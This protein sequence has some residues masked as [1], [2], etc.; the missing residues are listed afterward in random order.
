MNKKKII[1]LSIHTS[2]LVLYLFYEGT[3]WLNLTCSSSSVNVIE[4]FEI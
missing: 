2:G 3:N 1:P 4:N